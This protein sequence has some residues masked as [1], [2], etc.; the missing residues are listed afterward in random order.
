MYQK[1]LP[2]WPYP[3]NYENENEIS[4]DVLVLGGGIGGCWAA[5]SVAKKGQVDK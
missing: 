4:T 1:E 2:E 5:I 3:V